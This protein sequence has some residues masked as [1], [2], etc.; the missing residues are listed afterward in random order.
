MTKTFEIYCILYNTQYSLRHENNEEIREGFKAQLV[1]NRIIPVKM[2][3]SI[4][5]L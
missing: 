1:R 4:E 2:T 5:F 3:Y